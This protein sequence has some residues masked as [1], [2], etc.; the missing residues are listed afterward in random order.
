MNADSDLGRILA[1][2][3]Q[4]A[5]ERLAADRDVEVA[6]RLLEAY[7]AVLAAQRAEG[8]APSAYRQELTYACELI[9]DLRARLAAAGP[10]KREPT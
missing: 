4:R 1:L 9:Q 10:C 6:A 2:A 8:E 5:E 7:A 3:L